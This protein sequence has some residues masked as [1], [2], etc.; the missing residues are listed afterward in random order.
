MTLRLVLAAASTTTAP[1]AAMALSAVAV[2]SSLT[3]AGLTLLG[4]NRSDDDPPETRLTHRGTALAAGAAWL[5]SAGATG[6]WS[7]LVVL[8]AVVVVVLAGDRRVSRRVRLIAAAATA[9]M[10]APGVTVLHTGGAGRAWQIAGAAE[11]LAAAAVLAAGVAT[12]VLTGASARVDRAR[13][14]RFLHAALALLVLGAAACAVLVLSDDTIR[15]WLAGPAT[16]VVVTLGVALAAVAAAVLVRR[17]ATPAAAILAAVVVI[18]GML[19]N[20]PAATRLPEPAATPVLRH[21]TSLPGAPAVLVVPGRPGVNVVHLLTAGAQAGTRADALIATAARPGAGAGWAE[22]RLVPGRNRIWLRA[23]GVL[24]SIDLD[25]GEAAPAATVA[26]DLPECAATVA[27]GLIAGRS[28]PWRGCPDEQLAPADVRALNATV[29]FL[30]GRDVP[31][32]ALASDTSPRGVQAAAAV[33]AR[34]RAAGVRITGPG[35]SRVPYLLTSGWST[36][37]GILRRVAA[38]VLPAQGVYLAPWLLSAELLDVPAGQVTGLDFDPGSPAAHAYLTALHEVF[39]EDPA[40]TGGY[41]SFAGAE[42]A[43]PTPVRLFASSRLVM[44]GMDGHGGTQRWLPDGAVTA[45]T[46]PLG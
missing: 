18:V 11:P 40:C 20:R 21:L 26:A 8:L 5:L 9:V 32:I 7:P 6:R 23:A 34:A 13:L 29:D 43:D 38:D 45:V 15:P 27:G 1:A 10:L 14:W 17:P 30:A 4:G 24:T 22:V 35:D 12:T 44:P 3:A 16:A 28:V 37:D 36:A 33:R 42:A 19:V 31:A 2:V 25:A 39:P 46:G 41:R